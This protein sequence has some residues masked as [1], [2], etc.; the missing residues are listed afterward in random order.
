MLDRLIEPASSGTVFWEDHDQN[1]ALDSIRRDLEDLLNTRSSSNKIPESLVELRTSVLNSGM[2][3]PSTYNNTPDRASW[4]LLKAI[5][6][7]IWRFEPRLTDVRVQ[8]LPLNPLDGERRIRFEICGTLEPQ[9]AP[10]LTFV[11]IFELTS[12]QAHVSPA[13]V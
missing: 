9:P 5:E 7:V 4:H 3:D 2:P 6:E 12:G 1:Q 10:D 8:S 11:T 13:S